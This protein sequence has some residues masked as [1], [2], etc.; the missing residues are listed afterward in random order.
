MM[1]FRALLI[2][3]AL[4]TLSAAAAHAQSANAS[5]VTQV[6]A[7]AV[8]GGAGGSNGSNGG[9]PYD[10]TQHVIYGGMTNNTP[11]LG[12]IE[13]AFA[14]SCGLSS[15]GS[16]VFP[17]GGFQLQVGSEGP[18]CE[19]NQQAGGFVSLFN[20]RLAAL[21]RYG[22]VRENADAYFAVHGVPPP[23][24]QNKERYYVN[25]KPAPT[26]LVMQVAEMVVGGPSIVATGVNASPIAPTPIAAA[27]PLPPLTHAD[28]AAAWRARGGGA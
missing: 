9:N 14:N 5:Q 2:G 16:A 18:K 28:V 10:T 24:Q 11:G 7:G 3:S 25:G 23:G 27:A 26:A 19:T 21:A 4:A 20:D 22:Q 1:T 12:A 8:A 6:Y 17:N 15:G 13:S